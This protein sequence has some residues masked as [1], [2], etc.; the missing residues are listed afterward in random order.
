M[1]ALKRDS[2]QHLSAGRG[3]RWSAG[4]TL[5]DERGNRN[6]RLGRLG[7][8]QWQSA[9][10]GEIWALSRQA[11][12]NVQGIMGVW[13]LPLSEVRVQERQDLNLNFKRKNG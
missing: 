8:L 4:S 11:D 1:E 2:R 3:R 7:W 6:S 12:Q 9:V 10:G 13:A 5:R